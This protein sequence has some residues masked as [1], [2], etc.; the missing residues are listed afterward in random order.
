MYVIPCLSVLRVLTMTEVRSKWGKRQR[1]TRSHCARALRLE[2]VCH[3]RQFIEAIAN[4]GTDKDV[5]VRVR[6][7]EPRRNFRVSCLQA[8]ANPLFFRKFASFC[9]ACAS[10]RGPIMP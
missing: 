7:I 1:Q 10:V 4:T 3:D 9:I 6:H 8:R 5:S 2:T